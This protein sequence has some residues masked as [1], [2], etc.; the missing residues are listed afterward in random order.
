MHIHS[1]LYCF[2]GF[3]DTRPPFLDDELSE[4][5]N[6]TSHMKKVGLEVVR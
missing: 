2:R 5:S 6:S 1:V 3:I 4:W